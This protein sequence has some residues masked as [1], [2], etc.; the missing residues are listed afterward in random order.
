MPEILTPDQVARAR[1]TGAL[2]ADILREARRRC[3]VGTNL[4][5]IDGWVK[6]MIQDAGAE[7]CYVDYA[8]SF[9]SG[10][11]GNTSAQASTTPSCTGCRATTRWPTATCSRSTWRC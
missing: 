7:S 8:P 3:G 9:G 4:L 2:V 11:F 10:P 1:V 5:E 6:E